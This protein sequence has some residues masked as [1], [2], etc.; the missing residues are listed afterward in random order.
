M[1]AK[2]GPHFPM[3]HA[4]RSISAPPQIQNRRVVV[5]LLAHMPAVHP[6]MMIWGV[7]GESPPPLCIT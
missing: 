4:L 1:F 7:K 6:E 3:A 5:A 2:D